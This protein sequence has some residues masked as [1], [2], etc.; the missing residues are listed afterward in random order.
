MILVYDKVNDR[1]RLGDTFRT[2]E[3]G[4]DTVRIVKGKIEK[5]HRIIK[6]RT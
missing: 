1:E 4:E 3:T 2:G 6:R 5:K